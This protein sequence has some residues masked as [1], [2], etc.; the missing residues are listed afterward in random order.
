MFPIR[1]KNFNILDNRH[2]NQILSGLPQNQDSETTVEGSAWKAFTNRKIH[3][4]SKCRRLPALASAS[5][6]VIGE[7]ELRGCS[8]DSLGIIRPTISAGSELL[9]IAEELVSVRRKWHLQKQTG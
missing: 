5:F 1:K 3:N 9:D 2:T 6:S 4:G 8:V 7:T